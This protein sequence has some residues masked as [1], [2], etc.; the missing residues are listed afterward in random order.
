MKDGVLRYFQKNIADVTP[1][2]KPMKQSLVVILIGISSIT[3]FP[4]KETSRKNDRVILLNSSGLAI[5]TLNKKSFYFIKNDTL[6]RFL[7]GKSHSPD[8]CSSFSVVRQQFKKE[9]NGF[10]QF[11]TRKIVLGSKCSSLWSE[12]SSIY[13]LRLADFRLNAQTVSITIIDSNDKKIKARVEGNHNFEIQLKEKMDKFI[14]N[15]EC[16]DVRI[17]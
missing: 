2:P 16:N 7:I 6:T 8:Q 9:K 5:D 10:E 4:Q 14:S 15:V 17:E 13:C 12:E 11:G 3:A 1:V